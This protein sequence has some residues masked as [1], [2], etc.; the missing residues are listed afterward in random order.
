MPG[1]SPALRPAGNSWVGHSWANYR[2]CTGSCLPGQNWRLSPL[3]LIRMLRE[4]S[5]G[6]GSWICCKY[7]VRSIVKMLPGSHL[8]DNLF[9][10]FN[11]NHSM[12]W[13]SHVELVVKNPPAKGGDIR[14]MGSIPGFARS[15]GGGHGN[16]LHYSCLENPMDRGAWWV[17]VHGVTASDTTEAT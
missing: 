9:F 3:P 8:V 16:P 6:A 7:T 1:R 4:R 15:P 10:K 11:A 17:T 5:Q 12:K 2:T 13:A 14:D